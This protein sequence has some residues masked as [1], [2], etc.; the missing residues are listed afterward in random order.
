MS[1]TA[2]KC[3]MYV[4]PLKP[5]PIVITAMHSIQ[6]SVVYPKAAAVIPCS[7]RAIPAARYLSVFFLMKFFFKA[8]SDKREKT[9]PYV[10]VDIWGNAF[11]SPF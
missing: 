3:P 9:I 2:P 8:K 6:L 5:M 7:P 4:A 11:K 10:N 1:Y